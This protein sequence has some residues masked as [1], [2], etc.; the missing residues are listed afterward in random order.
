MKGKKQPIFKDSTKNRSPFENNRED[1][2]ALFNQEEIVNSKFYH[3]MT[4][5]ILC[6]KK[7][8]TSKNHVELCNRINVN[9]SV[10]CDKHFDSFNFNC[11][12][13]Q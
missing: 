1:P 6:E 13:S 5:I 4:R 8:E 2:Y 3:A 11:P 9:Y 10:S 7:C 12:S